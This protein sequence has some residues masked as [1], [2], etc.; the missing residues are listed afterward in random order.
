[1]ELQRIGSAGTIRRAALLLACGV[2]AATALQAQDARVSLSNKSITI[3]QAVNEIE[4]QTG[5]VIGFRSNDFNESKRVTL[6]RTQGTA[7]E[8]FGQLLA[9]TGQTWDVNGKYIVV[10]PLPEPAPVA[11][12]QEPAPEP[13]TPEEVRGV[14]IPAVTFREVLTPEPESMPAPLGN[15]SSS[16]NLKATPSHALKTNILL[17]ATLA[18]NLAWEVKLGHKTTFELPITYTAIQYDWS[19]RWKYFLAQPG[20]RFWNCEAFNGGFWSVYAHYG[21]YNFGGDISFFSDYMKT[22]REQGWFAGA[23]VGY[24]YHWAFGRWGLEAEIGA[25]WAHVDNRT[26][27]PVSQYAPKTGTDQWEYFGLTK[28]AITVVFMIK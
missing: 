25:G 12:I 21:R 11:T 19:K 4:A 17:D 24:G 20:V 9:G 1:M 15:Y 27:Q 10:V 3:E 28:A 16:S 5:Y 2:L 26:Y 18:L 22:H 23:G 13:A 14:H 6:S 7:K 8:I